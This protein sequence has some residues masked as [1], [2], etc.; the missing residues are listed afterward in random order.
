MPPVNVISKCHGIKT[1][2][3]QYHHVCAHNS[4]DTQ[5]AKETY[6]VGD[7]GRGESGRKGEPDTLKSHAKP[8]AKK[9]AQ[10]KRYDEIGHEGYGDKRTDNG[11][12]TQ[13]IGIDTLQAVAKLVEH[14]R[15]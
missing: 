1:L 5:S 4:S 9:P 7:T 3:H 11:Y 8:Y 6:E 14:K 10:R 15:Q 13:A 12:A 2:L